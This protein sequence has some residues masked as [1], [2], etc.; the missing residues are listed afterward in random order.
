MPAFG[1]VAALTLVAMLL[2]D[3]ELIHIYRGAVPYELLTGTAAMLL[4]ALVVLPLGRR[5]FSILTRILT[6]GPSLALGLISYSL[7][8]WHEPLQRLR[9]SGPHPARR[10]WLLGEPGHPRRGGR[11]PPC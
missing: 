6:L 10:L 9:S 11:G 1:L 7:F 8:L 5:L 4:L 3:R 2:A